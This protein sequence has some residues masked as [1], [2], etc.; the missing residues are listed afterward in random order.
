M[1]TVKPSVGLKRTFVKLREISSE[2][3][4]VSFRCDI[5]QSLCEK[6]C[7]VVIMFKTG[8]PICNMGNVGFSVFMWE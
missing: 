3:V 5:V 8:L 2:D 6:G 7:T 1:K 4:I